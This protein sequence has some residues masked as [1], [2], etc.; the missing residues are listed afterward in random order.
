MRPKSQSLIRR[1]VVAQENF[2]ILNEVKNLIV[3]Y[4]DGLEGVELRST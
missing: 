4:C 2:V 1:C 3:L